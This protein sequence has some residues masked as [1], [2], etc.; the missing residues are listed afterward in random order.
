M[1]APTVVFSHGKDGEPWGIKI[2]ALAE[3]ARGEGYA[4][5]SADYRGINDVSQRAVILQEICKSVRGDLV[6]WVRVLA[7]TTCCRLPPAC[8]LS[9]CS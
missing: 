6:L 8:T 5:D 1:S 9:V 3:T 2:A 7:P 4:V